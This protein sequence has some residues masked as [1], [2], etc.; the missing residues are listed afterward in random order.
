VASGR[1]R[2]DKIGYKF[3]GIGEVTE[4]VVDGGAGALKSGV[5]WGLILGGIVLA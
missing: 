2:E 4:R 1:I 3:M 5:K